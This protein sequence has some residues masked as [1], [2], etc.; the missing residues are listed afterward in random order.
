MHLLDMGTTIYNIET[1]VGKDGK[2]YIMECTP[3]AGGNRLAEMVKLSSGYDIIKLK[4][5]L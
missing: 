2:C 1:R 5:K 3:R 4:L